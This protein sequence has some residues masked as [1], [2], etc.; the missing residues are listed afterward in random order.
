MYTK[1][2]T[3]EMFVMKFT[4]IMCLVLA[5]LM[6]IACFAAC[7][8]DGDDTTLPQAQGEE[9]ETGRN[10]VKDTVPADLKFNGETVTFF[11]RDD[12]EMWKNEI[13]VEKTTNDTLFDSIYYRNATVEQRLGITIE[14]VGQAGTYNVSDSWNSTLRNCVLTKSGDYEAAAIY[15][16]TSSAL[17]VEGL[18]YNVLDLP[19]INLNQ[20]WW[21]DSIV[22]EVTLFDTLYYL[23]G[24]LCVTEISGGIC[25]FFNKD[26]FTELY[27]TQNIN[28]YEAVA[29]QKWTID[30]L[31]DLVANAW[32]DENS[33]GVISDG[34][35]VGFAA[36]TDTSGDG[37]MDAWIPA[38]G[39]SLTKM[40]DGYPELT[41]YDEHTV[42][43]YEKLQNLYNSNSGTLRA[44]TSGTKFVVGNQLFM[45][46]TLDSGSGLRDMQDDYGVLPLPKFNEEQDDYHTTFGN[47]SSLVVVL[48]T[49]TATDK[50]GATL[51]L[52]GAES[53][54][55]VTPAYF[56]ICL[57]GK[58][59]DEPED[60]E[61]YDRIINSFVYSF[62]FCYS[63]K[64]LNGIGSLF[65]NLNND[66]A[67][68]YASNKI[69]Y[70][71]A[72][73]ELIDKLDEI[74]FI[75]D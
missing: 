47:A 5:L 15:A 61:M 68:T 22:E 67:Q 40:V 72:L 63:T 48:S 56:E 38:M 14:Q 19:H 28:L 45:R 70:E 20:P 41:F 21:N 26:L 36:G 44:A 17:A 12:S 2:Y 27:Q 29:G 73:E 58:Y 35:I 53:Y 32:I 9:D 13:D 64:S 6:T 34:D 49:C 43:A 39:I 50:V 57:Q 59:S 66:L 16:S 10:A 37:S 55:Q 60:A 65:R 52:M 62:G 1:K 24:D 25:L 31:H 46:G 69:R 75:I 4:K 3:K 71:T 8:G 42:E 7:G 33:D 74:S 54:K 18:Y 30:Y 23:A 51:E 11:V